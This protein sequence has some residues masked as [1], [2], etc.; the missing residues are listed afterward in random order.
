[1]ADAYD[2]EVKTAVERMMALLVPLLTMALAVLIAVIII[3]VMLPIL[4][5][6]DLV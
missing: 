3:A 5:V 1:M 6:T 4:Q 2:L